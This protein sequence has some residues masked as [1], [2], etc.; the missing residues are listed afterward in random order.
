MVVGQQ[1]Q[2][3]QLHFTITNMPETPIIRVPYKRIE[4]FFFYFYFQLLLRPIISKFKIWVV[5][6]LYP[7][8]SH[9][10]LR[11]ARPLAAKPP[12][13]LRFAAT[14][15][16]PLSNGEKI[17]CSIM[18]ENPLIVAFHSRASFSGTA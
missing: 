1:V 11:L 12:A 7:I 15:P 16:P 13:L 5:A 3:I 10:P 17:F 4:D 6:V 8:K 18:E 14:L 2:I 9:D